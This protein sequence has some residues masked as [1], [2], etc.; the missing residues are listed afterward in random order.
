MEPPK[1]G[2]RWVNAAGETLHITGNVG[3]MVFFEIPATASWGSM[4]LAYFMKNHEKKRPL[5]HA[6]G[7]RF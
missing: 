2:E 6:T 1:K 4:K 5:E 7:G 3:G